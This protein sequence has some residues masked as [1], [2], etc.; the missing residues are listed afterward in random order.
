[1]CW[2]INALSISGGPKTKRAANSLII[3]L[4]YQRWQARVRLHGIKFFALPHRGFSQLILIT[5]MW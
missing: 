5:F 2:A 1:M 3:P 4:S